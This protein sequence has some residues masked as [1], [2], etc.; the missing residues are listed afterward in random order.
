MNMIMNT[1]LGRGGVAP[2]IC[3][4]G[5]EKASVEVRVWFAVRAG[6]G[7]EDGKTGIKRRA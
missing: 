7:D 4:D 3:G 6:K 5:E 1:R 2:W